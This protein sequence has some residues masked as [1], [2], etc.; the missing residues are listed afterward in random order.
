MIRTPRT[1]R[2]PHG[3]RASTAFSKTSSSAMD[4]SVNHGGGGLF[5]PPRVIMRPVA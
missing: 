2:T 4:A 5:P 1:S 3:M